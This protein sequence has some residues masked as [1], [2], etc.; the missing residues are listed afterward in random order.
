MYVHIYILDYVYS[1][2][3]IYIFI[4]M[5]PHPVQADFDMTVPDHPP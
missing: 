2:V 4:F 5:R 3:Y 1:S